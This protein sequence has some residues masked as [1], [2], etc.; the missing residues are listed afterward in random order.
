MP[1]QSYVTFDPTIDPWTNNAT[2]CGGG[3]NM[4]V[5]IRVL[6]SELAKATL[7]S[8]TD[9]LTLTVRVQ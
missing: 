4:Q 2:S 6:Q 8:Y 5:I 3:D 7:S 1:N 9:V